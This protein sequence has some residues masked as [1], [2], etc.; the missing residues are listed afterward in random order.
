MF[1]WL[2]A[3]VVAVLLAAVLWVYL[4]PHPPAPPLQLSAQTIEMRL[5]GEV[6]LTLRAP[7]NAP[8][9]AVT[10]VLDVGSGEGVVEVKC[11]RTGRLQIRPRRN[12]W[13]RKVLFRGLSA[14]CVLRLRCASP[15][16]LRLHLFYPRETPP[17]TSPETRSR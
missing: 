10:L 16:S 9:D 12:G 11:A 17:A 8:P 5:C 3:S 2:T 15:L 13:V 1:L 4:H 6:T 7:D 14:P